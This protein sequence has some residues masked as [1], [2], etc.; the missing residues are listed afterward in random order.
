MNSGLHGIAGP[1]VSIIIPVYNGAA[2]LKE[3]LDSALNQTYGNIEVIVVNDGSSDGGMTESIALSYGTKIIYVRKENGGVGSALNAG[4]RKMSGEYFSW[5]SADDVYYA[6]KIE[7]QM[8]FLAGRGWPEDV[9]LYADFELIDA[10][11]NL[12]STERARNISEDHFIFAL[13]F[14]YSV[15]GCTTLIPKKIFDDIGVF[16]EQLKVTQDCDMW[17]RIARKYRFVHMLEVIIRSR[18]HK[19]QGSLQM[20]AH[21]ASEGTVFFISCLKILAESHLQPPDRN[22][23]FYMQRSSYKLKFMKFPDAAEFAGRLSLQLLGSSPKEK[24]LY[25]MTAAKER[26]LYG[27]RRLRRSCRRL[28]SGISEMAGA[29]KQGS[30]H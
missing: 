3:A 15:S 30:A 23:A 14:D 12:L 27:T 8:T 18:I 6:D 16:N 13:V 21:V 10:Q 19:D 1:R 5:L 4:L 2:Y 17:F 11:S 28:F 7:K 25:Q 26:L 22:M 29:N 9:V 20:A 24:L